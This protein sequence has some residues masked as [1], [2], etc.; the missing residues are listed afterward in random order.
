MKSFATFFL[1][2]L[3]TFVNSSPLTKRDTSPFELENSSLY[4]DLLQYSAYCGV[5]YCITTFDGVQTGRLND[6][7]RGV[8]CANA[9]SDIYV[10]DVVD[11]V[12]H[13]VIMVQKST[14]EIVI[15]FQGSS[16]LLDWILDFSFIPI[17]FQSYGSSKGLDTTTV[18]VKDAK[19]HAG[20]K[21]A[22]QN[23]FDYSIQVLEHLR[24]KY[25][26]FKLVV[27]GHSLGG[28]L[29]SLVGL[30][31]NL[32]GYNPAIISFAGPKVFSPS[33]ASWV[34]KQFNTNGYVAQLESQ[35]VSTIT[36]GTYT[37]VTHIRDI[38]PCV[39]LVAMG[40]RHAGSE[41]YINEP[42]LPQ[43][44]DSVVIRGEFH[45]SYELRT[46]G[47]VVAR[48]F[49]DL[50]GTLRDFVVLTS[51]NYYFRVVT[52]CNGLMEIIG[53]DGGPSDRF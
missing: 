19:V 6:A 23:F 50:P 44:M 12:A 1:F 42:Y 8:D 38:V 24:A 53:L 41:F 10:V 18:D 3:A 22:S 49:Y 32:M 45:E 52:Q 5:S 7:C 37:R 35:S 2:L 39:P 36:P 27:T 33:L 11:E 48:V 26:G 47:S 4:R 21:V 34:D 40:Y 30:E 14:K 9:P 28:A 13:A 15:A 17:D 46:L 31:L 51:H 43:N 29:A 25:P 20:F 16:T